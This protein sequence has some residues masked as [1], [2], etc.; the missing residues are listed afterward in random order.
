[1]RYERLARKTP[2]GRRLKRR[3]IVRCR[4]CSFRPSLEATSPPGGRSRKRAT[5]IGSQ[6][7]TET[8]EVRPL[9][10]R[11][12][13]STLLFAKQC[14]CFEERRENALATLFSA[15]SADLRNILTHYRLTEQATDWLSRHQR[16][17][18]P[19]ATTSSN[20]SLRGIFQ[21]SRSRTTGGRSRRTTRMGKLKNV[22]G[23]TREMERQEKYG[24]ESGS[25]AVTARRRLM[26]STRSAD[27]LDRHR[28]KNSTLYN[29]L[30]SAHLTFHAF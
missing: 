7:G 17:L 13:H 19:E 24:I 20:Q 29:D 1:M 11:L 4:S 25:E 9:G 22:T 16:T 15:C 14:R 5:D 28:T 2:K 30:L 10:A 23:S 21:F 6:R 12:L 3:K 26:I 18:S 27:D 8:V